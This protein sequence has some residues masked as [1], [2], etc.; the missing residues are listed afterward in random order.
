M[1]TEALAGGGKSQAL[2]PIST[3]CTRLS[4]AGGQGREELDT[5]TVPEASRQEEALPSAAEATAPFH[6]QCSRPGSCC[7][8]SVSA[9]QPRRPHPPLGGA[10]PLRNGI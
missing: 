4:L 5:A 7:L 1:E 10:L 9:T 2:T 3:R 6:C 8:P